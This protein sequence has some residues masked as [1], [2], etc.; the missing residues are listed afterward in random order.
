VKKVSLRERL[1]RRLIIDP[2][3][4]CLLWTGHKTHDGY[5]LIF[6]TTGKPQ[7]LTHRIMWELHEG[8]IPEGMELD[9]LCS[10]RHCAAVAHLEPVTHLENLAR[11]RGYNLTHCKN[12]HEF[13]LFSTSW[14]SR[15]WRS[16]RT[17]NKDAVS[18]YQ[19]RKKAAGQP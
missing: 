9:H 6:V 7:K 5:G 14:D 13:D 2:E 12:G 1:L 16:C 8:P 10:V 15:G 19:A 3:T 17:C 18:R 11:G 4:G